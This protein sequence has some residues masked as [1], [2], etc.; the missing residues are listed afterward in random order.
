MV[1]EDFNGT[2]IWSDTLDEL[3]ATSCILDFDYGVN[4][5]HAVGY[6]SENPQDEDEIFINYNFSNGIILNQSIA[7][8]DQSS[9]RI[10]EVVAFVDANGG[11]KIAIGMENYTF[12]TPDRLEDILIANFD[13]NGLYWLNE[14]R[15]IEFEDKDE[16]GQLILTLDSSYIVVG[17]NKTQGLSDFTFN[18][19]QH[20]FVYKPGKAIY[21]PL[22]D[23][24]AVL[25]NLN[26]LV[27]V[28]GIDEDK[29]IQVYPNPFL[30]EIT[31]VLDQSCLVRIHDTAGAL[32]FEQNATMGKN[33]LCLE[34]MQKGTYFMEIEGC[35]KRIIKL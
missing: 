12:S 35:I 29:G 4:I 30:S 10:E 21:F 26:T 31:I 13:A 6:R 17:T 18:G 11:Q 34:S 5:L 25:S 27:S 15:T 20:I 7:I 8:N 23:N 24:N 1:C 9:K 2:Q 19:G 32:I 28:P 14:S 16:I 3:L 33:L 22:T